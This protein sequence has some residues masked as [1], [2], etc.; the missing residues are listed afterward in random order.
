MPKQRPI[1]ELYTYGIYSRWDRSSKDIPKILKITDQIP[2]EVD[3]EFGYVLKIKQG[4]GIKL[5]FE[6]DHP[7]FKDEDGRVRPPFTG[8]HYVNSNDWKFF[9]GDTIWEPVE[10][11]TGNW[12]LTT[13]YNGKV[14]AQKTLHIVK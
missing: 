6:I 4:K 14:V 5:D 12:T 8:E 9:L 2:A 7:S 11:K 1:F 10:D 3:V 13:W